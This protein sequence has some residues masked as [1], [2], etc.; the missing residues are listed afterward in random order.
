MASSNSSFTGWQRLARA[1]KDGIEF[2]PVF[3]ETKRSLYAIYK[4]KG[5]HQY[6]FVKD[7]WNHIPTANN[8]PPDWFY[9]Y[10]KHS[11]VINSQQKIFL[12]VNNQ[13][14]TLQ[15]ND[16]SNDNPP[17]WNI[18]TTKYNF[19]GMQAIMHSNNL[20]IIGGSKCNGYKH[21][22]LEQ[23]TNTFQVLHE[24]MEFGGAQVMKYGNKL[25]A[26]GGEYKGNKLKSIYMYDIYK[27]TW[28]KCGV[29]VPNQKC[30]RDALSAALSVCNEQYYLLFRRDDIIIGNIHQRKWSKSDVSLCFISCQ[31]YDVFAIE[32]REQADLSVFGYVRSQWSKLEI[33]DGSFPPRYLIKIIVKY[34]MTTWLHRLYSGGGHSKIRIS[35]IL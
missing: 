28:W 8:L 33:C 12:F 14:A 18:I 1:T 11:I 4:F 6:S 22:K 23:D 2:I 3:D 9:D 27:N 7:A 20:H 29:T 13:L 24:N 31:T 5:L 35:E 25:M 34:Y 10:E 21:L 32:D 15:L 19:H 17:R 26:F 30:G 16:S